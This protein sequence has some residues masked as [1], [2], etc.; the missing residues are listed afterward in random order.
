MC[1]HALP[2]SFQAQISFYRAFVFKDLQMAENA[3]REM[4]PA[5]S[6]IQCHTGI[7]ASLDYLPQK[8][9]QQKWNTKCFT[10]TLSGCLMLLLHLIHLENYIYEKCEMYKGSSCL[11]DKNKI[12]LHVW[13][14][15]LWIIM[16]IVERINFK[17]Y[18]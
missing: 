15:S 10:S 4:I 18:K 5:K 1:S 17:V 7:L 2:Q 14:E 8:S 9:K 11:K 12:L 6:S 3:H 16:G 13:V